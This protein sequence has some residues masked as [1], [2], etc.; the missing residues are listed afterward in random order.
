MNGLSL[1]NQGNIKVLFRDHDGYINLTALCKQ[2]GKEFSNWAQLKSTKEF[3]DELFRSLGI[4]RNLLVQ[5]V[6]TGP[7]ES[8]GTWGHPQVAINLGQWISPQYAVSVTEIVMGHH[9]E[10]QPSETPADNIATSSKLFQSAYPVYQLVYEDKNQAL[11]AT[12]K[13]VKCTTTVSMLELGEVT[14]KAK[15]QQALLIPKDIGK[16]LG[17][18][19]SIQVNKVLEE[20][21]LQV[22]TSYKG[23]GGKLKK[24][25]ELTK[26]GKQY[27]IYVD[28]GKK[29]SDGLPVRNIQWYERIIDLLKRG[30]L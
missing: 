22:N 25:W 7:N 8:R 12:D 9:K 21:G 15:V 11:L 6:T 10:V 27:A 24:R 17:N 29:H 5:S 20:L 26:E 3:L 19:S 1:L 4:T 18:I 13:A 14:L 16:R 23:K 30:K 28:T 2:A